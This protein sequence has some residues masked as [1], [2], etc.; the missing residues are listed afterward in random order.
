MASA[1]NVVRLRLAR[2]ISRSRFLGKYLYTTSADHNIVTSPLPDVDW[3]SGNFTSLI[4]NKVTKWGHHTATECSV[5]GRKYTYSQLVDG[6]SRWAG[7]LTKMGM[8]K[9]DVLAVVM[10]NCPEYPIVVL[11]TLMA[12]V[13]VSTVSSNYTAGEIHRQLLNCDAKMLIYDPVLETS[14]DGALALLQR[15]LLV[16]TNGPS[17]RSGALNLRHV[18]EDTN[19]AFNDP[20][21]LSGEELAMMPYSSG[22]TGP[23]KG[24]AISH[25]AFASNIVMYSVPASLPV[26]EATATSQGAFMCLLPCYHITGILLISLIGLTKGIKVVTVPKF[27]PN[28]FVS[29]ISS[30]KMSTLHLVPPLLNFLLHSPSVTAES[31]AHLE[32]IVIGAAPVSPSAAQRFKD[33]LKKPIFFQEGFGMTEALLTH[34]VPVGVD[35]VGTSGALLPNVKARVV[36]TVT[37]KDLKAHEDGEMWLKTPSIMQGYFKNPTATAE[38]IDADGWLHTGD[39][40]HYDERGFFKIVDRTKELIKVKGLQVSPSELED[41]LR[42]CPAVVDVGV[43]G[44][45][46]DRLGEAPRAY[47]VTSKMVSEEFIHGFLEDKVAPYKKL[48]GG[49]HFVKELP[50]NATG[51]LLRRELKKMVSEDSA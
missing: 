27:D 16:V 29:T 22:T 35:E 13:V 48:A 49:V 42:Q 9:G 51:K 26:K 20:V 4:L 23:P 37:G 44:V 40:G 18:F 8:K 30:H 2:N 38:T 5:T 1:L 10:P 46:D 11:G 33:K 17:A 39:I 14:V 34:M 43:V 25:N 28:T 12:G 47:V 50:K 6:A 7:M 32:H 41:L 36:D 31:M 3:P 19:I 45:P 24:V 15:P 21:E